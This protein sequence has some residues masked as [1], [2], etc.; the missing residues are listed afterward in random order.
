[1]TS[2]MIWLS[3]SL[4]NRSGHVEIGAWPPGNSGFSI[5]PS[6]SLSG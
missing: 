1:M 3:L 4:L 5:R 2:F 6:R